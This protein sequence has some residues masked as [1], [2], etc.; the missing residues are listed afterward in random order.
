MGG[1]Q[2][3][4]MEQNKCTD[5][6]KCPF[7]SA[8]AIKSFFH[9]VAHLNPTQTLLVRCAAKLKRQVRT[10]RRPLYWSPASFRIK[11]G[12]GKMSA[13]IV[14]SPLIKKYFY[15]QYN[16]CTLLRMTLSFNCKGMD[17]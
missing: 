9:N 1:T 6:L 4:S 14:N 11:V 12:T 7:V 5:Q 10:L 13:R 15:E 8:Y 16:Q 17:T 2:V 3:V